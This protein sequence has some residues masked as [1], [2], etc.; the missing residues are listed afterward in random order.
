[1]ESFV[2][3]KH[4]RIGEESNIQAAFDRKLLSCL[5]LC[6]RALSIH[7]NQ[8]RGEHGTDTVLV[9]ALPVC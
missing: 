1:M 6:C 9:E 3:G 5:C 8:R 7:L 4:A 2:A